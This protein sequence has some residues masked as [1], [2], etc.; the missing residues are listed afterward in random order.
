MSVLTYVIAVP[1]GSSQLAAFAPHD[2]SRLTQLIVLVICATGCFERSTLRFIGSFVSPLRI[3]IVYAIAAVVLTSTIVAPNLEYAFRELTLSLGLLCVVLVVASVDLRTELFPLLAAAAAGAALYSTLV[4]SVVATAAAASI[5][6]VPAELFFGYDNFRFF[7]HVQTVCLPL[8]A[9]ATILNTT[10]RTMKV[11]AW[12]GLVTGLVLLMISG[13]RATALAL[14]AGTCAALAASRNDARRLAV[15]LGAALLVSVL[16]LAALGLAL[17]TSTG[18]FTLGDPRGAV[19]TDVVAHGRIYLWRLALDYIEQS[20]WLGIGPMHYAHYANT[21]AA[22]PHNVYLQLAAEWGLPML[23]ACLGM[24]LWGLRCL[25]RAIHSCKDTEQRKVGTGL[26]AACIAVMVDGAF[27]GNFIMPMAQM[28]IAILIGASVSWAHLHRRTT[29][30]ATPSISARRFALLLASTLL[31]SQLWLAWSVFPE[32][33]HLAKHLDH[34]SQDLSHSPRTA[35][36][37]WSDG[38]F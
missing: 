25:W 8:L 31:I 11:V 26:L 28:W 36:R 22:H 21:K 3:A 16:I 34:V 30:N 32:A 5:P 1:I 19:L 20:P 27:S 24:A 37:L 6:L 10:N 13:G 9:A 4:L 7:N 12:I 2:F 15:H 38:W 29:V 35:P 23:G 33:R 18:S 17:P 14:T